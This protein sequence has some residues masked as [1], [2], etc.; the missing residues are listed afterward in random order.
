MGNVFY[1]PAIEIRSAF[2]RMIFYFHIRSFP[3]EIHLKN[4][5]SQFFTFGAIFISGL[6]FEN[7]T[8]R[9]PL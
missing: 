8:P 3:K 5:E 9:D 2:K 6:K 7:S 1:E 4:I